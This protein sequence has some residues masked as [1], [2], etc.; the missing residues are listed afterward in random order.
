MLLFTDS[1]VAMSALEPVCITVAVNILFG[2]CVVFCLFYNLS[3]GIAAFAATGELA[4]L[5]AGCDLC[6]TPLA[7]LVLYLFLT[8]ITAVTL[9]P[10]VSAIESV[11]F[12]VAEVLGSIVA[13]FPA[14]LILLTAKAEGEVISLTAGSLTVAVELSVV[15]LE[16]LAVRSIVVLTSLVLT[17]ECK[18]DYAVVIIPLPF[19]LIIVVDGA[20]EVIVI[21][22]AAGRAGV[23]CVAGCLAGRSYYGYVVLVLK[24]RGMCLCFAIAARTLIDYYS[25]SL[26]GSINCALMLVIVAES[27]DGFCVGMAAASAAV[28]KVAGLCTGSTVCRHKSAVL[29]AESRCFVELIRGTATETILKSIA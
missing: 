13:L 7:E 19:P 11:I 29:V 12:L 20:S 25:L 26:T 15:G 23:T 17:G 10:V 3:L 1:L 18:N 21:M 4:L 6:Y 24:L 8:V 9:I 22:L 16:A 14:V 28:V 5:R 27:G 2:I